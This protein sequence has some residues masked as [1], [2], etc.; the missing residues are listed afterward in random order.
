MCTF[1]K[2]SQTTNGKL[3]QSSVEHNIKMNLQNSV[4]LD[5][6]WG[7]G[8]LCNVYMLQP[9]SNRPKWK[10]ESVQIKL[11]TSKLCDHLQYILCRLVW[12]CNRIISHCLNSICLNLCATIMKMLPSCVWIGNV[13]DCEMHQVSSRCAINLIN[14]NN[15]EIQIE[16]HAH[17]HFMPLHRVMPTIYLITS[18][19][20]FQ[21][22]HL[23]LGSSYQQRFACNVISPPLYFV[24]IKC[25]TYAVNHSQF[26]SINCT[27]ASKTFRKDKRI[28]W[29]I[30]LT[31]SYLL[32]NI[33]SHFISS[34]VENELA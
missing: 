19:K 29:N 27:D 3:L 1:V 22:L 20:N 17:L 31:T 30:K 10:A 11:K 34:H 26:Y 4:R 7:I 32:A 15:F 12:E 2:F 24:E 9:K 18:I 5:K 23:L 8:I 14:D 28:Q 16:S 13:W 25:H 33:K 21:N 6:I